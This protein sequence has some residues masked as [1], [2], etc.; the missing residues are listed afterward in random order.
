MEV[1]LLG[2]S[3][4]TTPIEIRER[5]AFSKNQLPDALKGIQ[6]LPDLKECLIVSTCN[7]TEIVAVIN[8]GGSGIEEIRE[9]IFKFTLH[10][11]C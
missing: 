10:M 9:F 1:C 11:E 4:Q 2:V 6:A 5:I 3:H 7:R 8:K